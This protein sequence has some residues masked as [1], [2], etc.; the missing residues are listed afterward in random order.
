MPPCDRYLHSATLPW[1]RYWLCGSHTRPPSFSRIRPLS[2]R[3][4]GTMKEKGGWPKTSNS[5]ARPYR[6]KS[7]DW[8]VTD[9]RLYNKAF[10]GRTRTISRCSFCLQNDHTTS[11]CHA[12][13]LGHSLGGYWRS[14]AGR[15]SLRLWAPPR[16]ASSQA[17]RIPGKLAATTM[18]GCATGRSLNTLTAARA[19]VACT[20]PSDVSKGLRQSLGGVVP[21]H[22]PHPVLV[23]RS[24][25]RTVT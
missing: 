15:N 11:Q 13:R 23:Q 5:V 3:L 9:S 1:P 22:A 25:L 21:R 16:H 18:K 24:R 8:S 19:A 2:Y 20:P 10:T 4:S 12:T 17:S 7:L 14:R 6:G